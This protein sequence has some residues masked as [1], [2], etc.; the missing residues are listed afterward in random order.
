MANITE[1]DDWA[2]GVYQYADGDVL[3]GGPTSTETLPFR[4]LAGRSLYQRL[5]NVTPWDVMLA[6]TKGYPAGACVFHGGVTWRA[7]EL[8]AVEPGTALNK[9]ER[10]GF[11]SNELITWARDQRLSFSEDFSINVV[12]QIDRVIPG[13]Q[14][15]TGQVLIAQ[16]PIVTVTNGTPRTLRYVLQLQPP[17]GEIHY[18]VIGGWRLVHQLEVNDIIT[19]NMYSPPG[20]MNH[21]GG[22]SEVAGA[23][24]I[25][26]IDSYVL[27]PGQSITVRNKISMLVTAPVTTTAEGLTVK[28]SVIMTRCTN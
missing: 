6:A 12:T 10:W 7:K 4:Q 14:T 28:G 26:S 18:S 16:S 8:N 2:S 25:I 19:A 17:N 23:S 20:Q 21:V 27:T 11:S 9:W 15:L 3:D 22:V 13:A 24:G 1:N 5:R